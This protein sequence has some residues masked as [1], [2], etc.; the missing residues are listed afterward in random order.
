MWACLIRLEPLKRERNGDGKPQG[1]GQAAVI[2]AGAFAGQA[3]SAAAYGLIVS[4]L[5]GEA[6]VFGAEREGAAAV[7]AGKVLVVVS[8]G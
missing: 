4:Q 3:A 6:L 8:N 5:S 2:A 1:R 7:G